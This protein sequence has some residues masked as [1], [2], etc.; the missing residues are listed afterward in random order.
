VRRLFFP[1]FGMLSLV[2]FLLRV[3]PKPDRATYPCQRAAFPLA[4]A[5]V[6]WVTGVAA[7]T[8]LG[9]RARTQWRRSRPAL[10][11]LFVG[12][13]ALIALPTLVL[14]SSSGQAG[15]AGIRNALLPS[16]PPL[17]PRYASGDTLTVTPAAV[18][19]AIKSIRA[20][21]ADIDFAEIT[22]MVNEAIASAG[23]FADLIAD[24]DT[25]ILKP[26]LIAARDFTAAAAPLSPTVNGI[27]TDYRVIQAVVNAVRDVNPSGAVFLLEGSGVGMTSTNMA[28]LLW[29]TVTGLD[30]LIYL[31]DTGEAW[32]DTTSA[33]LLGVSLPEGKA[34][35]GPAE[36]RYWLSKLYYEADVLISLPVLK[37]HFVSG[38]TGAVKN[39]GIGATPPKIYGLG[40][41]YPNPN[42]RSQGINHGYSFSPR[43][44][45]HNWIHDF[46]MCRPVDFVIMDGLQGIQN[47]PLCHEF[48]NGTQNI[49]ED[50]KNARLMLAGRDPIALDAIASLLCGHDPLQVGHLVKLH[51][52][53]LGCCDPRL[54]RVKGI[55]VGDES[56][57]Y[58]IDDS[59]SY[60]KH[61]DFTPPSLVVR[62]CEAVGGELHLYLDVDAEVT[63]V[64]A[65]VNG[66]WLSEI[67]L[68]EFEHTIFDLDTLTVDVGD[69]VVA[70]AY[71]AYLNYV[72][73]STT[74]ATSVGAVTDEAAAGLRVWPTPCRTSPSIRYSLPRQSEVQLSVFRVDGRLV[75][76]LVDGVQPAGMH[77]VQW[78]ASAEAAGVYFIRLDAGE[79]S[80]TRRVVYLR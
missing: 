44:A 56:Q 21:A 47:G 78:D 61:S 6:I 45:L 68:G 69:E 22:T 46:Y 66:T 35:Y 26:N 41:P 75:R 52:D 63:K 24:G 16:V 38:V 42:E 3:I 77:R 32:F 23:G 37:N 11:V 72:S 7:S 19:G 25:V 71:D 57:D 31:E 15:L 62:G 48:I 59:G 18:V 34:L 20:Q 8:A 5:F 80:E 43:N 60:S 76:R 64:E 39:V 33:E 51:N 58:E 55:M 27:A 29:D 73:V 49:T 79:R 17:A 1:V 40:P 30:S 14:Q 54:I 10:A 70:Y 36:N 4:S 67:R 2:W 9:L 28:A 53:S 12:L 74:V 50:Q 13:A 65:S